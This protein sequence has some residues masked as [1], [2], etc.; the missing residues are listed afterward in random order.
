[1]KVEYQR[2]GSELGFLA[3][4]DQDGFVRWDALQTMW[5]SQFDQR[6][7]VASSEPQD[8]LASIAQQ[9]LTLNVA[10]EKLL[11]AASMLTGA[12]RALFV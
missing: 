10:D 7:G 6:S 3:R 5:V 12:Q 8:T 2:P 11:L 4:Y 9:A 1:M